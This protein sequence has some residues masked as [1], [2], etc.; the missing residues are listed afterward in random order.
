MQAGGQ[1]PHVRD[2]GN[3]VTRAAERT[4]RRRRRFRHRPL[5]REAA[6]EAL[7]RTE[8]PQQDSFADLVGVIR[9]GPHDLAEGH[10]DYLYGSRRR[11]P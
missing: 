4:P 2:A 3:A 9:D 1:R 7:R 6:E 8:T 11:R 10:D 5:I